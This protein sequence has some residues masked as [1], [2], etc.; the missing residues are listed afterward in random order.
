MTFEEYLA[1]TVW[2]ETSP[3][4]AGGFV[5]PRIAYEACQVPT[6]MK[7]TD[8]RTVHCSAKGKGAKRRGKWEE[9]KEVEIHRGSAVR[10]GC[11]N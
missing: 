2:G 7:G 1:R 9:N 4:M 6:E 11:D 5:F 10:L 3:R 8:G